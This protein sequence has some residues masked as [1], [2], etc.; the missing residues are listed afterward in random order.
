VL[1]IDRAQI[2]QSEDVIGV[3]MRDEH[4]VYFFKPRAQSLLPEI[5]RNIY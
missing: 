2:I 1:E 5:C 3:A 4:C